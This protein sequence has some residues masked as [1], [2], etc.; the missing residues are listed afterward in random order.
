MD[1]YRLLLAFLLT[2]VLLGPSPAGAEELVSGRYLQGAGERIEIELEIGSPPPS[3]VI[4]IQNLPQGV[5]MIDSKPKLKTYDPAGGV[6]KWLLN[7][8][9]PGKMTISFA[10]G[11][12]L[13]KGEVEGELRFRD[14]AGRM[15][16]VA[17]KN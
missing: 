12:P 8:P 2:G 6:A 5:K 4:V 13:A 1:F 14:D 17:L 3:L 15:V 9:N 10:L 7:K 16:S 11:R